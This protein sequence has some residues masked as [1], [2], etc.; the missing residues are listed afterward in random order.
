M[1]DEAIIV[2]PGEGAQHR[3]PFGDTMSWKAGEDA[4]YGGYSLHERVAPPGARSTP[5]VHHELAEAFYVLEGE[6]EFVVGG[7][8]VTG[9]AGTFVL[10]PKG[11]THAWTVRGDAP[12]RA[13][14]LFT[15]SAHRAYFDGVDEIVRGAGPGGPD[16][17]RLM[18]LAREHGFA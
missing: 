10:A 16:A 7:R 4:T 13:L 1:S 2:G 8:T 6:F 11:V 5:H 18:E 17:A 15:P 12:A 3:T 9:T 14:V